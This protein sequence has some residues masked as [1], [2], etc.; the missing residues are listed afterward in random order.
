[1]LLFFLRRSVKELL[2]I[3]CHWYDPEGVI[4]S[5]PVCFSYSG[6]QCEKLEK[7]KLL[8]VVSKGII[9][10]NSINFNYKNVISKIPWLN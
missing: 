7:G 6:F 3:L 4:F 2:N 1:M 8:F 10:S 5:Y 9:E